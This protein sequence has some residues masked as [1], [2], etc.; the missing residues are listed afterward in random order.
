[1]S[2]GDIFTVKPEV[3]TLINPKAWAAEVEDPVEADEAEAAGEEGVTSAAEET[4]APAE[5][6]AAMAEEAVKSEEKEEQAEEKKAD[7]FSDVVAA[8]NAPSPERHAPGKFFR[9]PDYAQTQ[10][11]VPAYILPSYLTCSAVYVRHP[12][13]RP[14]YSEIPSPYNADGQL[15]SLSWEWY[16]KVAPRMKQSRRL[17]LMDPQRSQDRK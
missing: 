3:I 2:P 16:Q 1:M 9:L 17:R 14:G 8:E 4:D 13:A 6:E 12:T 15:M 10:I 11:F 5:G 7:E